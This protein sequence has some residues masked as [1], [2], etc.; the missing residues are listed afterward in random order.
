MK[1]LIAALLL[2]ATLGGASAFAACDL[3]GYDHDDPSHRPPAVEPPP[4]GGEGETH[5]HNYLWLI[6]KPTQSADGKA[7]G[8]CECNDVKNI[9]LPALTDARY[10][11]TVQAATCA[12]NGRTKYSIELDGAMFMFSEIIPAT[13]VHN[14]I[15]GECACGAVDPAKPTPPET[16]EPDKPTPPEVEEPD[17]PTPPETEEPDK[18]TPPEVEE[19]DP[20]P[21]PDGIKSATVQHLNGF[22]SYLWTEEDVLNGK[23][24]FYGARWCITRN[25][26][27]VG[28]E[29]LTP[30]HVQTDIANYGIQKLVVQYETFTE[31]ITVC[32]VSDNSVIGAQIS[33]A[34][35]IGAKDVLAF[36]F[37][38]LPYMD[39]GGVSIKG[40]FSVNQAVTYHDFYGIMPLDLRFIDGLEADAA[41]LY[42]CRIVAGNLG[43]NPE[44]LGEID[45]ML[46]D[47]QT[48]E[49]SVV[50]SEVAILKSTGRDEYGNEMFETAHRIELSPERSF[51]DINKIPDK[52]DYYGPEYSAYFVFGNATFNVFSGGGESVKLVAKTERIYPYDD[53]VSG[54]IDLQSVLSTGERTITIKEYNREYKVAYTVYDSDFSNIRFCRVDG[55]GL[56]NYELKDGVTVESVKRELLGRELYVEYFEKVDGKYIHKVPVTED[57]LVGFDRVDESSFESQ[58]CSIAFADKTIGVSFVKAYTVSGARVLHTLKH[59]YGLNFILSDITVNDLGQCFNDKCREIVLYDNGVAML[60]HAGNNLGNVLTGYKLE[61]GKL[62]LDRHGEATAYL[63]ANLSQGTFDEITPSV[64]GG[65]EYSF[66]H[67]YNLGGTIPIGWQGTFTA[68]SGDEGYVNIHLTGWASTADKDG[69]AYQ[70]AGVEYVAT[71]TYGFYDNEAR[72]VLRFAD[73][74]MWFAIGDNNEL[75]LMDL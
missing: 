66:Y 73:K 51:I 59:A 45:I 18:P 61:G 58:Y 68:Y 10:E 27:S 29:L 24:D 38:A 53:A 5:T 31:E 11:K 75:T 25:D 37:N 50:L 20:A 54:D 71:W 22:G 23:F 7:T 41:G 67:G 62:T 70:V 36:D 39:F 72:F 15:D 14:Y 65:T 33:D 3:F 40:L 44:T 28:Y 49:Q 56:L 43:D 47:E 57:M 69:N 4:Q 1:K 8:T 17:K 74:N 13:G 32:V 46:Y 42:S 21:D 48:T 2:G 52:W 64:T 19:P 60:K 9:V 34:E 30:E 16:E 26:G 6:T 55:A 35:I 12:E 63:S